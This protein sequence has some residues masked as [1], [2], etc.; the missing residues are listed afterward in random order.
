MNAISLNP[1]TTHLLIRS[2]EIALKGKNR[3][4]FQKQFHRN[5]SEFVGTTGRIY[6]LSGRTAIL[7]D[8]KNSDFT[9]LLNQLSKLGGI[10]AIA[11]CMITEPKE[12]LIFPAATEWAK[13]ELQRNPSLQTF[14][15]RVRRINKNFPLRS[16]EL[17]MQLGTQIKNLYPKLN[18]DLDKPDL[19]LGIEI[20]HK[21]ALV[22]ST[23]FSGVKGLPL[24]PS[25]RVVVLLSGGIDSPVAGF[26]VM[27]RGCL[28]IFLHFHSK[29]FTSEDSILKVKRLVEH[30]N[31]LSP[32]PL[33]LWL[34]P[35]LEIQKAVRDVCNERYRTIHYRRLM[36]KI[37]EEFAIRKNAKAIVTGDAI[38]Q[39]ASQTLTNLCSIEEATK[40]PVLRPL[41]T[42]DKEQIILK[43]KALGT[44]EISIEP[45]DDSCILFA[46]KKPSTQAKLSILLEEERFLPTYELV[47]SAL[48][49]ITQNTFQ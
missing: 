13:Q 18:V 16:Q 12:D 37:A 10:A 4:I 35:F 33:E 8:K 45:H 41:I 21:H 23:E 25:E 7:L 6:S 9:L 32:V 2:H 46:P 44:Y 3:P 42:M 24:I 17:E 34:V 1:L 49:Q 38:G 20:R 28:P 22:Y 31:R 47:F 15:I 14:A 30:L 27:R 5:I 43:A 39:V 11:P 48:D 19:K 36:M 40:L 29:P 26:E